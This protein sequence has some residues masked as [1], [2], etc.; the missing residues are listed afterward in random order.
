[1]ARKK[2]RL[3]RP[4][5][6]KYEPNS[7]ARSHFPTREVPEPCTVRKGQVPGSQGE[8]HDWAFIM[9]GKKVAWDCNWDFF[10][11]HFRKVSSAAERKDG[12]NG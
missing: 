12:Q 10:Q 2:N 1:M 6:G 3:G 7:F 9:N 11:Y 4:L 8:W 5:P